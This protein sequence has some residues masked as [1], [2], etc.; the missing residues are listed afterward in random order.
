MNVTNIDIQRVIDYW[1]FLVILLPIVVLVIIIA[2]ACKESCCVKSKHEIIMEFYNRP[3]AVDATA[4]EEDL[5]IWTSGVDSP[6]VRNTIQEL[7][8]A[9]QNNLST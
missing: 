2:I 3:R 9:I 6:P 4:P 5:R 7:L 8:Y 1:P